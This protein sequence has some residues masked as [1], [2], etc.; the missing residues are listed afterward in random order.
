[1]ADRWKPWLLGLCGIA[2][3][4]I[5]FFALDIFG[6][7][8]R[9]WYGWWDSTLSMTTQPYVLRMS[10]VRAGGAAASAGIQEGDTLDLRAQTLNS[11]VARIF[12]LPATGA[13]DLVVTRGD[14]TFIARVVGSMTDEGTPWIKVPAKAISIVAA[15]W[16]LGC[17]TLIV[18]RRSSIPEARTIALILLFEIAILLRPGVSAVPSAGWSLTLEV[19]ASA[20]IAFGLL[21]IVPLS[22]RFGQSRPWRR[23]LE[24][25]AYAAITIEFLRAPLV[26]VGL[27]TLWFDPSPYL[28]PNVQALGIYASMW[29]LIPVIQ[30]LA[31]LAVSV[32]AVASSHVSER[33]RAAWLLLPLPIGMGSGFIVQSVLGLVSSWVAYTILVSIWN[34]CWLLGGFA[35]TYAILKRRVLDFEFVLGR[36]LVL[37]I[38]SLIVVASFILLEWAFGTFLAGASHVTGLLANAVLALVLGLSMQYIHHRVDRAVETMFF[39]KRRED[40]R[41]LLDFSKEAAYVT[42]VDALLDQALR[43]LQRHTD[44]RNAAVL[45]DGTASYKPERS[46]GDAP[47]TI[48]ENDGAVL[49]LKAWHKPLDPHQYDTA[50]RGA[51]V[52]PM[53]ARGRLLGMLLLGERAGGEAYAPGEIDALS[54]FAQGVGSALDALPTHREASLATLKESIVEAIA[55]LR[56]K[57]DGLRD[58]AAG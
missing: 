34:L 32:V 33:P 10:G 31:V 36:T 16:F 26:V 22:T 49:A 52:V 21:L 14:R 13:T 39:R 30:V 57:I 40:E 29:D 8:G 50:L 41:A 6:A 4:V 12:Q 35:V 45:L 19:F 25:F 56:R 47:P 5:A 7:G 28:T 3:V 54:Q 17:A 53:L 37:A 11:R 42:E 23:P 20:C 18:L 15:L 55:S 58:D 9:A 48:S 43:I 44:A 51:L 46:F 27:T 24:W 2:A 1:M 38:V